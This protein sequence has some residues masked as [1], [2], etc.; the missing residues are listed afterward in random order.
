LRRLG[1]RILR[2]LAANILFISAAVPL[3]IFPPLFNRY[4]PRQFCGEHVDVV[5]GATGLPVYAE[6]P[7]VLSGSP[8]TKSCRR[9][10]AATW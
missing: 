4:L 9:S 2:A 8:L 6:R 10:V 1:E 7:T 3:R 5:S